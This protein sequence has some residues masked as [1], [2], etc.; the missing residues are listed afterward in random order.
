MQDLEFEPAIPV[1]AGRLRRP[2]GRIAA[3]VLSQSGDEGAFALV[4]ACKSLDSTERINAVCGL[5]RLPD[6]RLVKPLLGLL[7]DETPQVRLHAERAANNHWDDRLTAPLRTLLRD[8]Y[9]E[10]RSEAVASLALH[11]PRDRT[12]LYLALLKDPDLNV[13]MC[14][15]SVLLRLNRDTIPSKPLVEMLAN[16]NPEVQG[17]ALQMLWQLNRDVVPR[18]DLLPLLGSP[19]LEIV[20]MAWRLIEGTGHL[21]PGLPDPLASTREQTLNGRALTSPEAAVLITNQLATARLIG[22]KVLERNGD[23]KAV[24]LALP[25]LRDTNSIVRTRAGAALHEITGLDL[26]ASSPA[27]WE[28]WWAVNKGTFSPAK[29]PL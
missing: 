10:I 22:L 7:S 20:T 21:R 3:E 28:K 12:P 9:R 11:E 17:A 24:D 29:G 8:P 23:A 1:L 25:L 19:H 4:R 15:L 14:A 5:E 18:A 13:Q 2:M 26:P 16:P 27:R 6:R